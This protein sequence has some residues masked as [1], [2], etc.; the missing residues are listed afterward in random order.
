MRITSYAAIALLMLVAGCT[1]LLEKAEKR[2]DQTN[3]S[4]TA[5]AKDVEIGR[6]HV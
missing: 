1:G 2:I 4:L 3:S 6:A 5:M